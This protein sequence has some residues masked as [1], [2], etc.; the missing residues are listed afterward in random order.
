MLFAALQFDIAWED[1]PANHARIESL[2]ASAA[3]P[4]GSF[5]LLP[6]LADT[7]FSLNIPSIVSELSLTWARS[8]AQRFKIYVQH[9]FPEL[10]PDARGRNTAAIIS[11]DGLLLGKYHKIHPFSYGKESTHYSAGDSLL[12]A[13]CNHVNVCPLVCYDLR[14]PEL[15]R[16]AVSA[17]PPAEIFTIGASWPAARQH[18]WRSLAIARAIENQSFVVAVN[19]IGNDP[20]VSYV[21]GSLIVS[22]KG[23]IL[24]EADDRTAL[25]TAELD[26]QSL[27]K[28]REQFPA[29]RDLNACHLGSVTINRA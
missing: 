15:F 28:W 6:E 1:K 27:R 9:G 14:F 16:L 17:H 13:D 29:L 19:R 8:L 4:P 3:L 24:A 25:L 23:D 2:I 12:I 21:G 7:G 11:P 20:H 5:L 18:H 10:G 26:L 22:P